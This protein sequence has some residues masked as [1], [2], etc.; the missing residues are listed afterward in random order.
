MLQ[1]SYVEK[2][3]MT[4]AID[5]GP[6]PAALASLLGGEIIFPLGLL[7]FPSC[8]RFTL[9]RFEPGDGN[10][11][12]FLV[13]DSLDQ[14]LS[15]PVIHPDL[16]SPDYSVPL[17][18]ELLDSLGAK[19]ESELVPLVIVTVR[20]RVENITVNLQGPL[21]IGVL[22]RIG[23]QSVV[24]DFPLRHPLVVPPNP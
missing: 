16:V 21:L 14:E 5:S 6:G 7:G 2:A 24:E 23:M 11:S 20:D 19:S 13:L 4:P 18:P 8:R 9:K 1:N 10:E 3:T 15:F 17:F 22:S 12:P